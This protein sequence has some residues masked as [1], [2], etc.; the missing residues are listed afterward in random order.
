MVTTWLLQL[1]VFTL[2]RRMRERLRRKRAVPKSAKEIFTHTEETPPT[3]THTDIPTHNVAFVTLARTLSHTHQR[4]Q[5]ILYL[6]PLL[7]TI[8]SVFCQR[9]IDAVGNQPQVLHL[10]SF[11]E[12]RKIKPAKGVMGI[13]GLEMGNDIYRRKELRK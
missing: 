5:G 4:L 13:K 10:L 6:D 12:V 8:K 2:L 7:S 3:Y 11:S 9:T 1:Q